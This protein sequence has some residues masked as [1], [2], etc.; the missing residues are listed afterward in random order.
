MLQFHKLT[1]LEEDLA[2]LIDARPVP[3]VLDFEEVDR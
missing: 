2:E 1:L 3:A